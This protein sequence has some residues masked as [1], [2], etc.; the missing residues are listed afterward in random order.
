MKPFLDLRPNECH[1]PI[2]QHDG[3][4]LFCAAPADY[5]YCPEHARLCR[6]PGKRPAAVSPMLTKVPP[7]QENAPAGFSE[8]RRGYLTSNMKKGTSG[9]AALLA[10]CSAPFRLTLRAVE[11]AP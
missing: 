5:P 2:G 4:Y 6:V 3:I 1:Y 11:A 10:D 8:S 9:K 7:G